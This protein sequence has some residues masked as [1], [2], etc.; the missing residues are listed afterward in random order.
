VAGASAA[1]VFA[2]CKGVGGVPSLE[3][4]KEAVF[5]RGPSASS[6]AAASVTEVPFLLVSAGAIVTDSVALP[7]KAIEGLLGLR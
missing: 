7:E 4:P 1:G 3:V 6:A 5:P 2:L